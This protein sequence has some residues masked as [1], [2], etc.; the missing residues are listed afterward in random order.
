MTWHA[1]FV[2]MSFY[3]PEIH[4]HARLGRAPKIFSP[5]AP[6]TSF[7]IILFNSHSLHA[8]PWG[9]SFST[10]S[11][12]CESHGRYFGL[13]QGPRSSI[14]HTGSHKGYPNHPRVP[15]TAK[16]TRPAGGKDNFFFFIHSYPL[17]TPATQ[18]TVSTGI[19]NPP[20][21][22]HGDDVLGREKLNLGQVLTRV[23]GNCF[24]LEKQ[25]KEQWGH[26]TRKQMISFLIAPSPV[27]S[28]ASI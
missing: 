14:G 24:G 3:T 6:A 13:M 15:G 22:S 4:F 12:V 16:E 28:Q 27:K 25:Q 26:D 19:E 10:A 9:P 2:K 17:P 1:C 18:H 20:H 23:K 21:R 5:N 11:L 7:S 8:K